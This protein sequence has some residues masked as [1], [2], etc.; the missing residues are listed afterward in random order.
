VVDKVT[1]EIERKV[2]LKECECIY[3]PVRGGV[4]HVDTPPDAGKYLVSKIKKS[5]NWQDM[6]KEWKNIMVALRTLNGPLIS[7]NLFL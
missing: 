3:D 6:Q 5:L 1:K 2:S 7:K 4:A